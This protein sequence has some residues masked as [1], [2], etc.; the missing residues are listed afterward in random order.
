MISLLLRP[1]SVLTSSGNNQNCID[2]DKINGDTLEDLGKAT[3]NMPSSVTKETSIYKYIGVS[4]IACSLLF[5]SVPLSRKVLWESENI[6]E[7]SFE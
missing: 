1:F 4:L 5:F 2:I 6:R 7:E 3:N